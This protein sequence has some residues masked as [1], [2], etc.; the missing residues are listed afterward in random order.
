MKQLITRRNL[1]IAGGVVAA[2]SAVG[3]TFVATRD[4]RSALA[5]FIKD[6]LPGVT[7]DEASVYRCVDDFI[8]SWS[9]TKKAAMGSIYAVLGVQGAANSSHRLSFV[10]RMVLTEFLVNS[11]FFDVNDPRQVVI[12]YEPRAPQTACGNPF[13]A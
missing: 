12:K 11:N 4:V 5:G 8:A 2:T 6:S 13:A 7:C 10:P 9:R 1:L 3:G